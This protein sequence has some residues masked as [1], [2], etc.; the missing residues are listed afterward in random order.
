MVSVVV[1]SVMCR[2]S[3]ARKKYIQKV[4]ADHIETPIM[5]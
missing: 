3:S 5:I 1:C 2:F 4:G